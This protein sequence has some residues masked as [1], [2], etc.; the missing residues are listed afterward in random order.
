MK[1]NNIFKSIQ[2]EGKYTGYP[3]I[4]IRTSECTRNCSW[5]DTKY[6][7]DGKEISIDELIYEINLRNIKND[8]VVWTGGEPLLQF[9]DIK[10]VIKETT[11]CFHHIE[12]NGDLLVNYD[13]GELLFWFDYTCISPKSKEVLQ[14]IEGYENE[15]HNFDI[16]VVTD[17]ENI[18]MDLLNYA[19]ILMPL[20]TYNKEK[21]LQIKKKVWNYCVENNIKYG[22]RLHIDI[23]GNKKGV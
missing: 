21:D 2:G 11:T 13:M 20:T 18:N 7:K 1:I 9:N 5:C 6:H 23:W 14:Y 12:T 16:K 8:I 3:A 4:F 15:F 19:T 17:L 22:N 10:E